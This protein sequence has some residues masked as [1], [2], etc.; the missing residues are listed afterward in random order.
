[1][2]KIFKVISILLL[3]IISIT[4]LLYI[5]YLN[6]DTYTW[7]IYNGILTLGEK[8]YKCE[9]VN[10]SIDLKL[11]KQI[12]KIEGEDLSF[13]VWSIKGESINEQVAI[14]GF[15][16]PADIYSRIK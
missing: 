6:L 15:M 10:N 11:E 7:D 1:M 16:F 13:R 4:V 3:V 9:L 12:G 14:K 5:R 8:Q 2:K